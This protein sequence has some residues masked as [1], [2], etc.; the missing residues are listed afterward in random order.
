LKDPRLGQLAGKITE[1]DVQNLAMRPSALRV[2]DMRPPPHGK[3][4]ID[5]IQPIEGMPN[6]TLLRITVLPNDMKIISVGP[7][8]QNSV[9]NHLNKGYYVPLP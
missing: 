3:G 6:K 4:Y 5:I 1:A 7:V 2:I 9:I 8:G